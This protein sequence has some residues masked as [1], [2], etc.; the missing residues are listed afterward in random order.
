MVCCG[1][2][3]CAAITVGAINA[4]RTDRLARD[5]TLE[6]IAHETR[7]LA[8][9]LKYSYNQ[10]E[11]DAFVVSRTPPIEGI[12][13]SLANGGT[14]PVDGSKTEEWRSRL[15]VIFASLMQERPN[16]TQ[17]RYIGISDGGREL[18]RTNRKGATFEH[19]PVEQLQ[20]KGSEEYF[21]KSLNLDQ[22]QIYFSKVSYNR[23][24][25]RVTEDRVPTIRAVLPVYNNEDLFGF[26]VIN[27]DYR[28]LITRFFDEHDVKSDV[29]VSTN[30]GD[31]MHKS[32]DG[33]LSRFAYHEEEGFERPS[34]LDDVRNQTK[35]EWAS[36]D[37]ES[38]SYSVR[39]PVDRNFDGTHNIVSTQISRAAFFANARNMLLESLIVTGVLT[40]IAVILGA[41]LAHRMT[42]P[43]SLMISN[44]SAA[45]R[46]DGELALP[47]DRRDEIGELAIAF[48]G[49]VNSRDELSARSS[50]IIDNVVDSIV[51]I[52]SQGKILTFNQASEN[53]FKVEREAVA[54]ENIEILLADPEFCRELRAFIENGRQL[55]NEQF[56]EGTV[57]VTEG[58]RDDDSHFP[59]ELSVSRVLLPDEM[60]IYS[61]VIRDITARKQLETVQNEFISTV[62][63]ELRTPLTSIRASLA[64]LQ[65]RLS[66]KVDSKSEHLVDLSLQSC[67][68]LSSLV[69]DILDLEKIAAGKMDFHIE[70]CEMGELIRSIV[71]RHIGIAE[72]H[73]VTFAL[74][75]EDG[76]F[77]ARVDPSRFNQALVNLLSN[78]AKFSSSGGSVTIALK[79]TE[80]GRLNVSVADQ[81]AGIPES[82]HDKVFERFAQADGSARRSQQGSGLGLN[83]A[84]TIIEAFGG[85]ITFVSSEGCG[86]TFVIDLPQSEPKPQKDGSLCRAA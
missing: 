82:F 7:L 49:L 8:Q 84:K 26:I 85:D 30:A 59:M 51:T 22:G 41:L 74:K 31:H 47:L 36:E 70:N 65:Q 14:D 52:D 44:I 10:M 37:T 39:L 48:Q 45:I 50:S 81:G 72:A 4:F 23:E 64:I 46:N 83:I 66:G 58:R 57:V 69:N 16:Y 54:G 24:R 61:L 18:V 5:Y 60:D 21:L 25:N 28:S 42:K 27:V 53:I 63:H 6:N 86:T 55:P 33:H 56:E 68:R 77:Y 71:E 20:R 78:A 12:I 19:V 43:L 11:N 9:Q 73:D 75:I 32:A 17:M 79:A 1:V 80:G 40:A 3:F 13:R 38:L 15:Q 34:I 62:N 67:E 35:Q 29:L 76:A 2:A